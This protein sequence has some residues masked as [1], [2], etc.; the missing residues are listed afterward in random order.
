MASD[1][2]VA[3]WL[4]FFF[5]FIYTFCCFIFVFLGFFRVLGFD[6]FSVFFSFFRSLSFVM[7]RLIVWCFGC[8]VVGV[9]VVGLFQVDIVIIGF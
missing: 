8:E 9:Y 2:P 5:K 1:V 7:W 4:C 3:R 6:D